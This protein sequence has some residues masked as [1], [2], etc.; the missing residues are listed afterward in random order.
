MVSVETYIVIGALRP[1]PTADEPVGDGVL[2][3]AQRCSKRA[4]CRSAD[5]IDRAYL[6]K[7]AEENNATSGRKRREREAAAAE[8]PG[9]GF[10]CWTH[11]LEAWRSL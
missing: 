9:V 8:L 2:L 7:L 3:A 1:G 10:W 5:R 11:K 6:E 4:G